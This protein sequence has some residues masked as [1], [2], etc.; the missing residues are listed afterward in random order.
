M[1]PV[2]FLA[3][4]VDFQQRM[5]DEA[6]ADRE[7]LN[8]KYAQLDATRAM[9]DQQMAAA[10]DGIEKLKADLEAAKAVHA[11][12]LNGEVDPGPVTEGGD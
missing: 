9:T 1:E 6:V 5:L 12:A 4:C 7:R 10:A 2:D 3:S 11:A 8:T